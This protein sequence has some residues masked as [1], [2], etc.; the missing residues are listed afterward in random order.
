LQLFITSK[1]A[2]DEQIP[3]PISS[4]SL[5][6][7]FKA[8]PVTQISDNVVRIDPAAKV[9]SNQRHF[10]SRVYVGTV[11]ASLKF[12]PNRN[13]Y[14]GALFFFILACAIDA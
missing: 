5:R 9:S 11:H 13:W 7:Q 1:T 10:H 14:P 2:I 4:T 12:L 3:D 8:A 6:R